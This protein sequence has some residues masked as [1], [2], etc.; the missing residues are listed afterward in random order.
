[1]K[2]ESV[3][4]VLMYLFK[5]HLYDE[6]M[7]GDSDAELIDTLEDA[8]F[9]RQTIFKA[10]GW[11]GNLSESC[12]TP[13]K[14]GSRDAIR[15]YS[16]IECDKL[17]SECRGLLTSLEQMRILKPYTREM[18]INQ[19]LLL[20]DEQIDTALIKWITL[21]VL[22]TQPREKKALANM[23]ILVLDDPS[24]RLH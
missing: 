17:S 7:F 13:A 9:P 8:G 5:H 22:F 20:H 24:D 10:L 12:N 15:V 18:V 3:L 23:E 19:T 21:M 1:M 14:L 11:L 4:N 2:A 16:Q 6:A